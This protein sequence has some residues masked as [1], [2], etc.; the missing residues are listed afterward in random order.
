MK[1]M[2]KIAITAADPDERTPEDT[3]EE[4][5]RSNLKPESTTQEKEPP[6]E[7]TPE[8]KIHMKKKTE[9]II[10]EEENQDPEEHT[11]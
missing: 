7:S 4:P 2:K 6:S 3:P 10:P 1:H 11:Q 8:E 5:T 9:N